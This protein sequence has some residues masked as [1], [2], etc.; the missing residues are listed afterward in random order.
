M[1]WDQIQGEWKQLKGKVQ[2]KWGELTDDEVDKIDGDREQ[3]E[4]HIQQ[5]YGKTKQEAKEEVD[6]WLNS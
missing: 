4:G 5:K 1:N 3:L 6:S 2:E